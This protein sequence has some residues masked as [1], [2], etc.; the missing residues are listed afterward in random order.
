[1][2]SFTNETK[3]DPENLQYIVTNI[4]KINNTT[5]DE[6]NKRNTTHD[7][8]KKRNTTHDEPN[9]RSKT[10]EKEEAW[11]IPGIASIK[12][13][14]NS[15]SEGAA[16]YGNNVGSLAFQHPVKTSLGLGTGYKIGKFGYKFG[17]KIMSFVINSDIRMIPRANDVED[18]TNID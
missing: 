13:S 12:A 14:L 3:V 1:M 8:P 15:F 9:K 6:P 18:P 11:F 2:P 4:T 16:F 5:H 17:K 10:D 7:E